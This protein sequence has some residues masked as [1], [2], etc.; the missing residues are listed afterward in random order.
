MKKKILIVDDEENI[1]ISL[2]FLLKQE[3]YTI[4][5]AQNGQ[6]AI[7]QFQLFE[8]DIILLDVMM[9]IM[10][11]FEAAQH[12]RKIATDQLNIIFLTAKG[13]LQDKLDGYKAGAE[14]YIVKPFDNEELLMLLKEID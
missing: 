9:P 2:S 10:N 12:I 3:G 5:T 8:P 6:E 1:V 7:K 11:G 14:H 4:Q 13:T